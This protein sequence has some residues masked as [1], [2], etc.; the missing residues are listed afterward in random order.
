MV[1]DI[2]DKELKEQSTKGL[3]S[4]SAAVELR[5]TVELTRVPSAQ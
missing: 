5:V 2:F 3:E 4:L 1:T